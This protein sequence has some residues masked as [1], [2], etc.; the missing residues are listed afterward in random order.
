MLTLQFEMNFVRGYDLSDG[1]VVTH[2]ALA[3]RDR[4]RNVAA[5]RAERDRAT[6]RLLK[7][8]V[9]DREDARATP[10]RLRFVR[11]LVELE[12]LPALV[13]SVVGA[14]PV[15]DDPTWAVLR[16]LVEAFVPVEADF[17]R[18]TV[19]LRDEH[20]R[21]RP[22]PASYDPLPED[23]DE[24]SQAAVHRII[25]AL[26]RRGLSVVRLELHFCEG[27]DRWSELP[28]HRFV[29][30]PA[31][32]EPGTPVRARFRRCPGRLRRRM[33]PGLAAR[34]PGCDAGPAPGA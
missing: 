18:W 21:L 3:G 22:L 7:L 1:T 8:P 19:E 6:E 12:V 31:E 15:I 30:G 14:E 9:R 10:S 17:L 25:G 16:P 13:E 20:G 34:R 33:S 4:V 27:P 28:A 5:F 2:R 24:P 23:G 29:L 11:E 26:E 32:P